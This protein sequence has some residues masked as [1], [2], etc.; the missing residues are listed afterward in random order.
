MRY[1]SSDSFVEDARRGTEMEG[2]STC[3]V[4]ASDLSEIG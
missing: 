2:T 1:H 3:W 4:V